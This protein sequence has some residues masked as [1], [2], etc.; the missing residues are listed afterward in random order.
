MK[1]ATHGMI[2]ALIA[3]LA[4]MTFAPPAA[5]AT[6]SDK[7]EDLGSILA[8]LR[9]GGFVVYFRHGITDRTGVND[10][11]ADL[12]KCETQ[13]NLSAE[14]RAQE[15]QIGKAIQALKI[16]IGTVM[17]SPVCRCKDTAR[18]V[19][20]A[21]AVDMDLHSA[22]EADA[23]ETQRVAASLRRMLSTPPAA[24]TNTVIVAHAANLREAT[25][26]WLTE[27]SA[28]V[29]RPASGGKAEAIALILPGDWGAVA[30]RE[31][32]GKSK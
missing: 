18:L 30:R 23:T 28:Y 31:S 4:T 12:A 16:P 22:V 26:I 13:R 21:Y 6:R 3:V 32:S 17:T 7:P 9:K 29:F 25:G 2:A 20:G 5:A 24:G 19:S 11:G 1:T 10:E 14:G 27:G 15:A 8:E